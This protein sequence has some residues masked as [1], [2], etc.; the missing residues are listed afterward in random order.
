V[1]ARKSAMPPSI[2]VG[3]L[4]QRSLFGLATAPARRAIPRTRGVSM[5]AIKNE[6]AG[7]TESIVVDME[8]NRTENGG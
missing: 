1:T 2:A 8:R 5:T 6:T 4:C 3:L 7:A